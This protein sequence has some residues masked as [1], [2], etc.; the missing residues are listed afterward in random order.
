MDFLK[1]LSPAYALKGA[2]KDKS[3]PSGK[4]APFIE[5]RQNLY[6]DEFSPY[7]NIGKESLGNASDI[8]QRM[9]SDPSAYLNELLGG[10]TPNKGFE[11]YRHN[12]MMKALRQSGYAGGYSGTE[13]DRE[14]QARL[15]NDLLEADRDKYY[16]RVTGLQNTGLTGQTQ[17][18]GLG[19]QASG[20]MAEGMGN[21]LAEQAQMAYMQEAQKQQRKNALIKMLL[22][23]GTA[24]LG[25]PA[26]ASMGAS[27]G[28][29]LGGGFTGG[30]GGSPSLDMGSW[31]TN[32]GGF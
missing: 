18:G 25:G 1:Y 15:F 11:D 30:Y 20:Q 23:V 17:L 3:D 6:R 8:Y 14:A 29:S 24:A 9:A 26:G 5:K 22:G 7:S 4:A 13:Y 27:F 28:N 32:R 10:Y 2:F 21:T 19:L 16:E 31:K 12:E